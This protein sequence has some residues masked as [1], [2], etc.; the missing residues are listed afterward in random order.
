MSF[1]IDGQSIGNEQKGK[2]RRAR[3]VVLYQPT[4]DPSHGSSSA[5]V[6][7]EDLGDKTNNEAEYHALLRLLSLLSTSPSG[8]SHRRFSSIAGT[9]R[10]FSDS[11][12]LVNQVNGEWKVQEESLSRLR[13]EARNLM[14]KLGSIRLDWV[15]REKNYAGLWLEG[16]WIAKQVAAEKFL[17]GLNS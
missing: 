17:S 11:K 7:V 12:L 14:N 6:L 2:P 9:V 13:E 10:I 5:R 3:I 15:P 4:P 1:Y 8:K 16:Q